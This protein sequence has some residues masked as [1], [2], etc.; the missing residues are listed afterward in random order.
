MSK[1]EKLNDDMGNFIKYLS[2]LKIFVYLFL[3]FVLIPFILAF[4]G[5]GFM[6][7]INDSWDLS[8]LFLILILE[9]ITLYKIDLFLKR[10]INLRQV[11]RFVLENVNRILVL[12]SCLLIIT[13]LFG[14]KYFI[15]LPNPMMRMYSYND[16]MIFYLIVLIYF[17]WTK[18]IILSTKRVQSDKK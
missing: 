6:I 2:M 11:K 17:I 13:S 1:P 14:L 18:L 7:R 10:M 4:S 9:L 5:H 3:I 8:F 15:R 12:I 16:L